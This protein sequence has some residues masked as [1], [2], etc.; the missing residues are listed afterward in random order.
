MKFK[1]IASIVVLV[2]LIILTVLFAPR[3]QQLDADGNPVNTEV[4]Q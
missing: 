4:Q 3:T 1:V 2:I